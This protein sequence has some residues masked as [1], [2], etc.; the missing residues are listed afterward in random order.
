M[1]DQC[2]TRWWS[3]YPF[4]CQKSI[5]QTNVYCNYYKNA[6]TLLQLV[7][8]LLHSKTW[9]VALQKIF[10]SNGASIIIICQYITLSLMNPNSEPNTNLSICTNCSSQHWLSVCQMSINHTDKL[11]LNMTNYFGANSVARVRQW[12][13]C[14]SRLGS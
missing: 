10:C 2:D 13:F 7:W 4:R 9:V 5:R 6:N 12:Y 3:V 11:C 1:G 8:T 14:P